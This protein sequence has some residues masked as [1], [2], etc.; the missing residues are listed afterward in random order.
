[1]KS[2]FVIIDKSCGLY[3]AS[4]NHF[5][6]TADVKTAMRWDT[7]ND[8]DTDRVFRFKGDEDLEIIEV[9]IP[10]S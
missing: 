10:E 8:A 3:I 7:K 5:H 1:M 2:Y 9:E 4:L 6:L